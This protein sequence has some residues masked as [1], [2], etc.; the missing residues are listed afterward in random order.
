MVMMGDMLDK[1]E[2][3]SSNVSAWWICSHGAGHFAAAVS[4]KSLTL[5]DW[6]VGEKKRDEIRKTGETQMRAAV[7][8]SKA[9]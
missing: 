8:A 6:F 1:G 4:G 7:N 2:F 3:F 9:K 5:K